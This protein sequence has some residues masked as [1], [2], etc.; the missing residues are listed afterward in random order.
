MLPDL[1]NG[2]AIGLYLNIMNTGL[3]N[4]L[5]FSS[6]NNDVYQWCMILIKSANLATYLVH[7]SSSANQ[8]VCLVVIALISGQSAQFAVFISSSKGIAIPLQDL[9]KQINPSLIPF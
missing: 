5:H 3:Y 1:L 9:L 6:N 8:T 4:N 7:V 2:S